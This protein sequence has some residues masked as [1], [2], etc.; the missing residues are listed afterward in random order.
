MR[1]VSGSDILGGVLLGLGMVAKAHLE[2]K[3]EHNREETVTVIDTKGEKVR[4]YHD[5]INQYAAY[6]PFDGRDLDVR[7]ARSL[8]SNVRKELERFDRTQYY[9]S[10]NMLDYELGRFRDFIVQTFPAPVQM[11]VYE[12]VSDL[13]P[14]QQ[15]LRELRSQVALY[16]QQA[17][18]ISDS[19]NRRRVASKIEDAHRTINWFESYGEVGTMNYRSAREA[20]QAI[21]TYIL[22]N[23]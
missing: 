15:V 14:K 8:E 12:V 17:A 22:K 2:A 19:Y 21:G 6:I 20:V 23:G 18:R 5:E 7:H 4:R 10:T 3:R 11:V 13:T 1:N 16:E 9:A